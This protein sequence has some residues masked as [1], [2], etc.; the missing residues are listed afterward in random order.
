MYPYMAFYICMQRD[1]WSW[2]YLWLY[3]H[4]QL[5][6]YFCGYYIYWFAS[7][8]TDIWITNPLY[9]LSVELYHGQI[10]I[11]LDY[12]LLTYFLLRELKTIPP[13]ILSIFG[14]L[15]QHRF[16][17]YYKSALGFLEPG[18]L[19]TI[20]LCLRWLLEGFPTENFPPDLP[21]FSLWYKMYAYHRILPKYEI[22]S[23]RITKVDVDHAGT[24][25]GGGGWQRKIRW[26]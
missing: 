14:H 11:G 16:C 1:Y 6:L 15:C 5:S 4:C 24:G 12:N 10:P 8:L 18:E 25:E 13:L 20:L 19:F 21:L 17:L 7:A 3:S 23:I 2:L 26:R 22:E 9:V